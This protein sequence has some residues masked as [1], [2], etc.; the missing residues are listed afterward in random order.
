[1]LSYDIFVPLGST[2]WLARGYHDFIEISVVLDQKKKQNK[3]LYFT[4][5]FGGKI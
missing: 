1:M 4:Y 3:T 2:G 5:G